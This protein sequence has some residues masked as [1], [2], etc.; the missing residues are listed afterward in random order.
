MPRGGPALAGW[1]SAKQARKADLELKGKTLEVYLFLL[2]RRDSV[3]VREVQRSLGFSSPSVAFH[4][5]EKLKNLGVVSKDESGQYSVVSNVD[6]SVLQAFV[7]VGRLILPRMLFYAA[8][9][10]TFTLLYVFA[11]LPS[12]NAYV[13]ILGLA[14]SAAFWFEAVRVWLKKPW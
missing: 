6:V 9:F 8:F 11:S 13:L 7:R 12:L 3:G 5:L 2:K 1:Q 4:H 14:S 10:T